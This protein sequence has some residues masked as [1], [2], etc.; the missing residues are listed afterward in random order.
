[1]GRPKG[2]KN[3]KPYDG[4]RIPS[5]GWSL[6]DK[7]FSREVQAFK[8]MHNRVRDGKSPWVHWPRTLDGFV[9]FLRE[10]GMSPKKM[11]KPSVGRSD[12]GRGYEPGN[13]VWEPH[14]VNSIKRK[15][16][17]YESNSA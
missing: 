4:K 2:S 7:K 6:I 13:I 16:T 14:A 10:V 12:H 3:K 9:C 17:R 11:K 15:G 1:V 8:G 5:V